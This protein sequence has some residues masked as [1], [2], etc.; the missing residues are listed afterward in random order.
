MGV[1]WCGRRLGLGLSNTNHLSTA[2][3]FFL[4]EK[5]KVKDGK[6]QSR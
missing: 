4:C 3:K 5:S 1:A 2:M 6:L